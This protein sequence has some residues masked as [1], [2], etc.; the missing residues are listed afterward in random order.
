[1]SN[2]KRQG[3]KC[4]I[5]LYCRP[6]RQPAPQRPSAVRLSCLLT[7]V[8]SC[9]SHAA[10]TAVKSRGSRDY[11]CRA[12]SSGK[13]DDGGGAEGPTPRSLGRNSFAAH[14]SL[15]CRQ[16]SITVT[17]VQGARGVVADATLG[18]PS[19][20]LHSSH[21]RPAPTKLPAASW[22]SG[23]PAS[24]HAVGGPASFATPAQGAGLQRGTA[25]GSG[26]GWVPPTQAIAGH[27]TGTQVGVVSALA[28]V[29]RAGL[30]RESA[31]R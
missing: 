29:L 4:G 13:V 9:G 8:V 3:H 2:R 25:A 30:R 19:V 5:V 18:G 15:Q 28:S 21:I 27:A 23:L 11:T 10:G 1:M 24:V 16:V 17:T 12:T 31:R 14:R 22:N 6:R 20:Y 7:K 26:F